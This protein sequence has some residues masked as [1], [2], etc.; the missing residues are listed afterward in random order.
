MRSLNIEE[1]NSVNGGVSATLTFTA[2][3]SCLVGIGVC[4]G[5]V[6]LAT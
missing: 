5:I 6:N 1:V 4:S 3:T 2:N